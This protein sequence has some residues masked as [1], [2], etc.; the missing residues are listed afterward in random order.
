[1]TKWTADWV[2]RHSR[3]LTTPHPSPHPSASPADCIRLAE[4]RQEIK[5]G[6]PRAEA[7]QEV[8][9][10]VTMICVCVPGSLGKSLFVFLS[11]YTPPDPQSPI[12]AMIINHAACSR[13]AWD[14]KS[15]HIHSA[16][17][18]N[19]RGDMTVRSSKAQPS[20]G[21]PSK[22][23]LR[24]KLQ[25][26]TAC[27]LP[28]ASSRHGV[29]DGVTF[30]IASASQPAATAHGPHPPQ[31]TSETPSRPQRTPPLFS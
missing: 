27:R 2:K 26:A 21:A 3:H 17:A 31:G 8:L 16:V 18:T 24:S 11:F 10:F 23:Q 13:N 22:P 14:L 20:N 15:L 7:I 30:G 5:S 28:Q 29:V 9:S 25:V 6:R 19:M 1:M 12:I 4:F